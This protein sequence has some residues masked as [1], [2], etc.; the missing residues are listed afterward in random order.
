MKKTTTPFFA[1][2]LLL[3]NTVAP[4]Q[5]FRAVPPAEQPNAAEVAYFGGKNPNLPVDTISD[6]A[7]IQL[8]KNFLND[9]TSGQ[10]EAAHRRLA[11][12]FVAYGPG[13]NDKLETDNLLDQWDHDGQLFA[14]QHLTIVTS[15]VTTVATGDNRSRWVYLNVVWT[16]TE[17]SGLGKPVRIPFHQLAQV[18]NGLIERTYTSYGNDQIFY[19]LGFPI[20]AN[21]PAHWSSAAMKK[22]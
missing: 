4:A 10:F 3:W 22:Q 12:G 20:Y 16:A 11:G 5:E 2:I 6:T 15:S 8:V 19:E 17:R 18:N 1:T 9:L 21:G 13:Y 7:T 14:D